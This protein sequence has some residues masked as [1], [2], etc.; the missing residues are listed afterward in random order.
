MSSQGSESR[1]AA[2]LKNHI[3]YVELKKMKEAV[4]II[5]PSL[6]LF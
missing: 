6:F 5:Q 2:V 4:S 3:L 1:I